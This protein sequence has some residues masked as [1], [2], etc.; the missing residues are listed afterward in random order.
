MNYKIVF[1]VL[2]GLLRFLGLLMVVPLLVAYYY[3]ESLYP[4]IVAVV[5]TGFTGIVLSLRYK[6]NEEWKTRDGFAIVSLGWL[7]AAA[8][9]AIPFVFDGISPLNALFES[10]SGFTT[11]GAT[12]FMAWWYGNHHVVHCHSSKT[13]CCRTSAVSC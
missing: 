9:G 11:T 1:N 8:F 2:G 5:L 10:M 7:A 3:D 13:W 4:F 12:V 6:S